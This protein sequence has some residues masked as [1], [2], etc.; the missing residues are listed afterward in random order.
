MGTAPIVELARAYG[1]H[2]RLLLLVIG[3]RQKNTSPSFNFARFP[4][5]QICVEI[6]WINLEASMRPPYWRTS[7]VHQHDL[8]PMSPL[9]E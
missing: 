3:D 4:K 1:L 7:V 2:P 6:L 8:F 5:L 9:G